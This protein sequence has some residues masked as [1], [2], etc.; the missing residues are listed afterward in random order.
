M[1]GGPVATEAELWARLSDRGSIPSASDEI[2]AGRVL[3]L[4]SP[5]RR[6]LEIAAY[7]LSHGSDDDAT[8][9]GGVL[10]IRD[11]TA[12]R[13]GQGLR[14]AFLG[15]LSHELRTPVTSIYAG[16]HGAGLARATGWTRPP[17]RTSSTTSWPSRTGCSG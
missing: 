3:A 11:V 1:L 14:E 4:G 7:P 2:R 15:L 13:Q 16:G 10:V 5:A 17:A 6:W 8:D 12:F 9:G